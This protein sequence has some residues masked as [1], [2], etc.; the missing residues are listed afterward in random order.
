MDPRTLDALIAEH[1]MRLP[2]LRFE[3]GHW[4]YAKNRP[5][6]NYSTKLPAAWDVIESMQLRGARV[7]IDGR[8]DIWDVRFEEPYGQAYDASAPRAVCLAAIAA[9]KIEGGSVQK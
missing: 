5:I 2:N 1:V 3:G 9:L 6:P 8:K 4:L 7:L